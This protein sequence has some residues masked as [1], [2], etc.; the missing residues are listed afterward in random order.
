MDELQQ[1]GVAEGTPLQGVAQ[2]A[3]L[4]PETAGEEAARKDEVRRRIEKTTRK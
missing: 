1:V 3:M 2:D 4:D